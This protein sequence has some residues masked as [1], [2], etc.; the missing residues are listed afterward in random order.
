MSSRWLQLLVVTSLGMA[1]LEFVDAFQIEVPA[2]AV[3]FALAYLLG[4]W[5]LFRS[6]GI[7]AG[8]MLGLLNLVELVF[9]PAYSRETT[10]DW[11]MQGLVVVLAGTGL[12]GAIA[13][14]RS[15][16]RTRQQMRAQSA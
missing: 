14:V 12:V 5:G 6:A 8:C 7:W 9:L 1:V 3:V 10:T 15:R 11:V 16:R 13:V 2:M 4:V